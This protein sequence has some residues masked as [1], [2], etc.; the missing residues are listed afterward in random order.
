MGGPSKEKRKLTTND[1]CRQRLIGEESRSN[2]IALK[3]VHG[4]SME[5]LNPTLYVSDQRMRLHH[6]DYHRWFERRVTPNK[7]TIP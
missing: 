7:K 1:E 4:V 2:H 6:L 3:K 5:A